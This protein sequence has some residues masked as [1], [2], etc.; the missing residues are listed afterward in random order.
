[1]KRLARAC[2]RLCLL[3]YPEDFRWQFESS[4]VATFDELVRSRGT[5]TVLPREAL[6]KNVQIL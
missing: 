2:Y 5:I 3:A 6:E 1:M 4:M